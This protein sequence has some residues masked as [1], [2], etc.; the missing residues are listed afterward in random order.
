[1]A[2]LTAKAVENIKP[3]ERR[4]EIPDGG[5]GL[6][7]VV[8]PTGR[9]S[10]AVRY[11]F[12]GKPK[13][14]TLDGAFTLAAARKA[15]ADAGHA[16]ERGSDPAA[17]KTAAKINATAAAADTVAAICEEYLHREG[18]KLRTV[19][20]RAAILH[21]L[22]YPH[23]GDR[24]IEGIKRSEIIRLLDKIEDASGPRMADVTLAVLRRVFHWH[25]LRS[26][27][28]RSP[29][30]RGMA[31][32]NA[33]EHRRSRT[34]TDDELR[35]VWRAA[36]AEN[37]PFGALIRFLLLTTARRG[38]AAA[39]TWG[40]I[41]GGDWVLPAARNKVKTNLVRPLSGAAVAI[42]AERPRIDGANF[43]FTSSG[44]TPVA[45]F[46]LPKERLDA[47]SGVTGWRLHDLRRTA[48]SLLSRAG[49]SADIAEMCLGHTLPSIRA[50]Y[51]RY[52]YRAE[53][54]HAF[55]ALAA[56]IKRIVDPPQGGVIQLRK[57]G[58]HA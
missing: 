5:S 26:D 53:M 56:Q 15:A 33:V 23:F 25:A 11:R 31:R 35:R 16:L 48:R 6:Y 3:R 24:P 34:L 27:D 42:L 39:M 40:E 9:K 47:A 10:W 45:S 2:R 36:T 21:R 28:F 50:T 32:Q 49:I 57:A 44:L 19:N 55:E 18:K 46:S 30:V 37:G 54:L 22:I 7:L 51:D 52:Q 4:V 38:E 41:D 29:I 43:V 20:Q 12:K 17:A 14:L 1:M 13:K 8:Q 58:R